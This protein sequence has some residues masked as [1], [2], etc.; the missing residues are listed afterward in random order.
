VNFEQVTLPFLVLHGEEDTV[1]DPDVSKALYD[2]ASSVD[3]TMKLYP[4]MWHGLT[5][6]EPDENIELVFGD[7]ISWLD[8]R[9]TSKAR[10]ESFL[11]IP[12]Y[13]HS[14]LHEFQEGRPRASL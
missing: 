14:N 9:A 4:G 5:S 6:G 11:P 13:K 7:I 2:K 10:I 1:T 3:K 12:T 8:E